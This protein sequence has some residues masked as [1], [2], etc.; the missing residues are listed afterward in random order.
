MSIA[1]RTIQ[2][3]TIPPPKIRWWIGF[4]VSTSIEE[5]EGPHVVLQRIYAATHTICAVCFF[6]WAQIRKNRSRGGL[7]HRSIGPCRGPGTARGP[8]WLPITL[9]RTSLLYILIPAVW[10]GKIDLLYFTKYLNPIWSHWVDWHQTSCKTRLCYESWPF[11]S[12][13]WILK[14]LEEVE[15][16]IPANGRHINNIRYADDTVLLASSKAGLQMLVNTAQISSEKFGLKLIINKTKVMVISKQSSIEPSISITVNNIKIGQVQHFNY[17]GSWITTDGRCGKE[18]RRRINLSK[19]SFNSM[20]N[21]FRDRQ[22]SIQLK[23]S[24]LKYFVWPVLMYGCETS[25]VTTKTRKNFEAAEMWF[26][27]RILRIPWTA[28][29]TNVS[30]LQETGQDRKLLC[31]IEQRQLKFL[32]HVIRKG[33]LEDLALSGRIPG[34]RARGA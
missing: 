22:L 1:H 31:C 26:H 11:Q 6:F 12:I 18:I 15:E 4:V 5:R 14:E 34:K 30:V 9:S 28:H 8:T 33:E 32:G 7:S 19:I 3:R 21:I 27:R 29:Q 17:L 25:T 16:G 10:L 24:L 2:P 20:K 13:Q 23:T